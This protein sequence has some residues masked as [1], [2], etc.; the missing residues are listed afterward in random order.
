MI[1][2]QFLPVGLAFIM[3]SM[4]LELEIADFKRLLKKPKAVFVGV[5]C[6]VFLLPMLAFILVASWSLDPLLSLG[7]I[8]AAASPGGVTSNMLTRLANGDSALSITLT[9]VV[10]LSAMFTLPLVVSLGLELYAIDGQVT[11]VLIAPMMLKVFLVTTFPVLLGMLIR[12]YLAK[13]K[14]WVTQATHKIAIIFFLII[15]AA[16][17]TSQWDSLVEHFYEVGIM[18]LLLNILVMGCGFLVAYI[19]KLSLGE[20][21]AITMECGVQNA[22]VGIF[23]ATIILDSLQV[24]IP[25][26]VYAVVMNIT[27]ALF[28]VWTRHTSKILN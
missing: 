25:N 19:T 17:F 24:V 11:S 1:I 8:I 12:H 3:L 27:A 9:A 14:L 7:L 28:I 10:S 18:A 20:R 2:N 22:A 26:L 13:D 5:I 15:V 4:G 16:T 6:Q 23:T 21:I